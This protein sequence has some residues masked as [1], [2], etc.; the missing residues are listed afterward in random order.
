MAYASSLTYRFIADLFRIITAIINTQII[1]KNTPKIIIGII[2][3]NAGNPES[4]KLLEQLDK[5]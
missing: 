4:K 3:A 5:Y 2:I 1:T